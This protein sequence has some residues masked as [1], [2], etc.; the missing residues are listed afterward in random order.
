[1]SIKIQIEELEKYK[2][3][4]KVVYI[5]MVRL[6]SVDFKFN[7]KKYNLSMNLPNLYPSSPAKNIYLNHRFRVDFELKFYRFLKGNQNVIKKYFEIENLSETSIL[8]PINWKSKFKFID[9]VHE[10]ELF[11]N[12][13]SCSIL[14]HYLDN[15]RL[16]NDD[17]LRNVASYIK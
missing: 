17:V 5:P 15:K 10:F 1:M 6:V 7:N 4:E 11:Q 3:I 12:I 8:H 9:I 14:F 2:N 16:L 13:V